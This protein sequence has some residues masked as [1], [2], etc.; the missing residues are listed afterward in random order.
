MELAKLVSPRAMNFMNEQLDPNAKAATTQSAARPIS[1]TWRL[2]FLAAPSLVFLGPAVIAAC[3]PTLTLIP[4]VLSE[5]IAVPYMLFGGLFAV[6]GPIFASQDLAKS[7]HPTGRLNLLY[8]L[9]LWIGVLV[10]N[11]FIVF[12]MCTAL[13]PFILKG[14]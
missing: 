13:M 6:L 9:L 3:D 5:A 14:V 12:A 1:S 7:V 8:G 11:G 2:V 4:R 10:V